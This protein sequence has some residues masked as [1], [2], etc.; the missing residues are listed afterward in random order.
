MTRIVLP[1]QK[2]SELISFQ[3][4]FKGQF[5]QIKKD[6]SVEN[7]LV[8]FRELKFLNLN[9][10]NKLLH[11]KKG[12]LVLA[13]K[14]ALFLFRENIPSYHYDLNKFEFSGVVLPEFYDKQNNFVE[15]HAIEVEKLSEIVNPEIVLFPFLNTYSSPPFVTPP[16]RMTPTVLTKKS[17]IKKLKDEQRKEYKRALLSFF[18][19]YSEKK[20]GEIRKP[21]KAAL[22]E[23]LTD[24]DLPE[25][26]LW[27]EA[28]LSPN[29]SFQKILANSE[30][31]DV[32]VV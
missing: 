10:T 26:D 18:N 5:R 15:L 27:Y 8:P 6:M 9:N 32:F 1:K 13:A 17:D 30:S 4:K 7:A 23:M 16:Q 25:E 12:D 2:G 22:Y 24:L 31:V 21:T 11:L 14:D 28:S 20:Y 3:K 19:A 29:P